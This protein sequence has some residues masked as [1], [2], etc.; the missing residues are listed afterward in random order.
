MATYGTGESVIGFSVIETSP[1]INSTTLIYT[2]PPNRYAKVQ[3]RE[4]TASGTDAEIVTATFTIVDF[5]RASPIT[6][7]DSGL[8]VPEFIL[9]PG[10]TLTQISANATTFSSI[11]IREFATP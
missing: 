10:E 6:R 5:N 8:I 4:W 11:A 7:V 3:L 1:A 9:G 2:V